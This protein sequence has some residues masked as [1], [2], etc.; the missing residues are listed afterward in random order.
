MSLVCFLVLPSLPVLDLHL[1]T[2]LHRRAGVDRHVVAQDNIQVVT[3]PGLIPETLFSI[4]GKFFKR[5]DPET[6]TFVSNIKEYADRVK[7]YEE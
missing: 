6:C 3:D 2:V 1:L 7:I 4:A 5:F